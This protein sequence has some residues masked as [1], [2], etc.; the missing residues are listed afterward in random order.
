M[1]TTTNQIFWN[2]T[3]IKARLTF[4]TPGKQSQQGEKRR[5]EAS[6]EI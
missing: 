5:K 3:A 1:Q 6:L 4:H 2:I